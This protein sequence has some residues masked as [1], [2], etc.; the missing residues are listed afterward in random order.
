[1]ALVALTS[2]LVLVYISFNLFIFIL[3]YLQITVFF[4]P[5]WCLC[6]VDV[7]IAD[8]VITD[9]FVA[10]VVIAVIACYLLFVYVLRYCLDV[11]Y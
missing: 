2:F 1:M 10:D 3:I 11:S 6:A 5:L 9:V 4:L 8:V 7:F